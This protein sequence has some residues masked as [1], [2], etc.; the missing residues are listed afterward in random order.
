MSIRFQQRLENWI[1]EY[2]TTKAEGG[3]IGFLRSVPTSRLVTDIHRLI[4]LTPKR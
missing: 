2:L 4:V 1:D 3:G